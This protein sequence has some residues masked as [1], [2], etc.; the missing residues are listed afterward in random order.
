MTTKQSDTSPGSRT[1]VIEGTTY[2]NAEG[3][4]YSVTKVAP[5]RYEVHARPDTDQRKRIGEFFWIEGA[6]VQTV[7]PGH[8]S[9]M[10]LGEVA[11]AFIE[12]N[13][14]EEA[15][16]QCHMAADINR[17]LSESAKRRPKPTL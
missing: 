17:K 15:E 10:V 9:Q 2:A 12:A 8:L 4:A 14:R 5:W 13:Q 7:A 11:T 3:S 1:V 6:G 16:R